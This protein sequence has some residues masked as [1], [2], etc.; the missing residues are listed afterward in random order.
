MVLKYA[1]SNNEYQS[2][3]MSRSYKVTVVM[4]SGKHCGP[5][6]QITPYYENLS[7]Q[8]RQLQFVKVESSELPYLI[9]AVG[10]R[11]LPTFMFFSNGRKIYE[12]TGANY[13]TLVNAIRCYAK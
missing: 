12:F 8:Y 9:Q 6:Q 10:V 11:G 4:F 1:R 13:Q 5:C 3:I 7:N 2:L